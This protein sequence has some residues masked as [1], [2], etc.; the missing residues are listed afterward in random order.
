MP[1]L[2]LLLCDNVFST[3]LGRMFILFIFIIRYILSF[4]GLLCSPEC[5][6]SLFIINVVLNTSFVRMHNGDSHLKHRRMCYYVPFHI[7]Q[8]LPFYT[9]WMYT[10]SVQYL[11]YIYFCLVKCVF[12]IIITLCCQQSASVHCIWVHILNRGEYGISSYT[13]IVFIWFLLFSCKL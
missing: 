5:H 1:L 4:I 3:T 7:V 13:R 2:L 6:I 12:H 11:F 10:Q 9:F 8:K